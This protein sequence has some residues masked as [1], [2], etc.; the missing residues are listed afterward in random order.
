M[1]TQVIQINLESTHFWVVRVFALETNFRIAVWFRL[2]FER[3]LT[4]KSQ[5][6][7]YYESMLHWTGIPTLVS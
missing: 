5:K 6:L 3:M 2:S 4:K 7:E 1:S